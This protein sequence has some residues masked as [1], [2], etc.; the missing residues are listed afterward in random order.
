MPEILTL[1]NSFNAVNVAPLF[2]VRLIAGFEKP[3]F[4]TLIG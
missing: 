3:F 4:L 2:F 1:L